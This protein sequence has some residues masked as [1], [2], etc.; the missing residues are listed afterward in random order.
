MHYIANTTFHAGKLDA[1]RRSAVW[2]EA[3]DEELTAPGLADRLQAR[4]PGLLE[5][6]R[7][8]IEAVGFVW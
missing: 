6:M 1:A 3:T 5:A 2:P 7:K 4:L 8:D